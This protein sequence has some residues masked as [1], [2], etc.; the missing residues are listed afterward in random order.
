MSGRPA[1]LGRVTRDSPRTLRGYSSALTAF[2]DAYRD[3]LEDAQARARVVKTI[4]AAHEAL[5]ALGLEPAVL[6][7]PALGGYTL[8]GLFN[9]AFAHER[10]TWAG[11][12]PQATIDIAEAGRVKAELRLEEARRLRRNPLYWGDRL[13]RAILG[14]PV[15]LVGLILRVPPERLDASAW[16]TVLRLA[17]LA[18]EG[19]LVLV[20]GRQVGWW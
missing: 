11:D 15:Y 1:S 9:T 19:A 2:L 16:G 14:F 3:Y 4:P 18:V 20:T 10:Y 6:P 13:L 5:N 8:R 7:P 12:M 17:G